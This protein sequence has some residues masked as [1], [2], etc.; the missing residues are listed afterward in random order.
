MKR[1]TASRLFLFELTLDLLFFCVCAAVCVTLLVHAQGLTAES[2]ALSEACAAAQNAAEAF[3]AENG[4]LPRTAD[5]L[6]A[7][8]EGGALTLPLENGCTLT[9]TAARDE[10]ELCTA[11]IQ[12][13]RADE[14][15]YELTVRR[16]AG[17]VGS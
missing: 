16:Y 4:D 13:R 10:N 8:L 9:M 3:K 15:V 2:G 11:E 12:V 17:E 7:A 6:G 1:L 5:R 14:P